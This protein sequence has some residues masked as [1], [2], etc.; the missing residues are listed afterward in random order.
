MKYDSATK[1]ISEINN[2][3]KKLIDE[4]GIKVIN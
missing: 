4:L 1:N 3:I 2:Q